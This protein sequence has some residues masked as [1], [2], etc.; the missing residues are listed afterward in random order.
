MT[1]VVRRMKPSDEAPATN[2]VGSAFNNDLIAV[3]NSKPIGNDRV[4]TKYHGG[5]QDY[6]KNIESK[7]EHVRIVNGVETIPHQYPFMVVIL[8]NQGAFCGGSL[9]DQNHVLTGAHCLD[10]AGA[11]EE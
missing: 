8:T 5:Y 2:E 3:C 11:Q 10:L 7:L 1:Y 9:I 4:N 6:V